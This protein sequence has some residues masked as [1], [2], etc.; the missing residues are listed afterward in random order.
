MEARLRLAASS[1]IGDANGSLELSKKYELKYGPVINYAL[2]AYDAACLLLNAIGKAAM[3]CQGISG[4]EE[5]LST[6]KITPFHGIA[7]ANPVANSPTLPTSPA[8][9]R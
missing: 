9:P 4:R 3:A 7:N 6:I 8:S 5:V 2:N 1:A